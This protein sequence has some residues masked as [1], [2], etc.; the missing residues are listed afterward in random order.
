MIEQTEHNSTG[1]LQRDGSMVTITVE[2]LKKKPIGTD[3]RFVQEST[4]RCGHGRIVKSGARKMI[5]TARG[6]MLEIRDRPG[7]HYE[8]VEEPGTDPA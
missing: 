5:R 2:K 6:S 1:A 4:G 8:L 7:W 3:I